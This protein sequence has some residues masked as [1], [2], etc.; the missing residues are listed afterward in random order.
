[1]FTERFKRIVC[2]VV[3]CLYTTVGLAHMRQNPLLMK[4]ELVNFKELSVDDFA[5]AVHE[6]ISDHK[7]QLEKLLNQNKG[8]YTFE[9]L[10]EPLEIIDNELAKIWSPISHLNAVMGS[11]ELREVYN[12]LQLE[13]TQYTQSLGQNDK[14]YQAVQWIAESDGFKALSGPQKK[15]MANKLL[16]FKLAGV[17]LEPNK[18]ERLNEI[19]NKL[20]ELSTK[21]SQ[22]N[23]D[24]QDAWH[25]PIM[26]DEKARLKGI[27]AHIIEAAKEEANKQNV[28][29]WVLNLDAAK[30]L[31]ILTNAEDRELR[32]TVYE[33]YNTLSSD[34]GKNGGKWDNGPILVEILKLRDEKAN[35][36]GFENYAELSLEVKMANHTD[37]VLGF[38]TELGLYAKP[39][40]EKDF[41]DVKEFAFEK[42]GLEEIFAWDVAYYSEQLRQKK[43]SV[44]TEALRAFFPEEK[45]LSGLFDLANDLYGITVSEVQTDNLWD[46]AVKLYEIKDESGH[47]RGKFYTDLYARK[48]KRSG[49]WAGHC[50][51][52]AWDSSR[53]V[54]EYPV[55]FLVTNFSPPSNNKSYLTHQEVITLFH[56]FGHVLH[57]LLTLVDYPSIAGNNG[58]PWDAIELPSQ[59]HENW[60]WDW[61]TLQAISAHEKTKQPINKAFYDKLLSARF[62]QAGLKAVRQLEFALFDFNVHLLP[63]DVVNI[64]MVQSVLDAARAQVSV[65]PVPTYNRF[66][67]QFPHVFAGGYA[68]GYYSYKWALVLACDAFSFFEENGLHSREA[69]KQFMQTVLEQGGAVDAM[70]LYVQFRGRQPK[71][72]A[73]LKYTGLLNS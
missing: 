9:N 32:E 23:V 20:A 65:Y 12:P 44:S 36:L 25:Y 35:L 63:R 41:N 22:N 60:A 62:F 38:L 7:Y 17:H 13:I 24:A 26:P 46:K 42:D 18:R 56:E 40:A 34:Q 30:Y 52:R 37:E 21:Y 71:V 51:E 1:M 11:D 10:M 16:D 64:N 8:Q 4:Q 19:V 49:A 68:A 72:D 33:A 55:A 57:H 73:L 50:R 70:D 45:V 58:V 14:L 6:A 59:M 47:L 67:N 66:Q 43:Y 48:G 28:S 27:P 61:E 39:M 15:I 54:Q 31:A 29:G 5:P 69:G 3:F 2:F 53:K